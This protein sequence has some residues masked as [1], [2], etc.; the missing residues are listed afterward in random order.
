MET[1]CPVSWEKFHWEV[2]GI[3]CSAKIVRS[4]LQRALDILHMDIEVLAVRYINTS[5]YLLLKSLWFFLLNVEW[6]HQYGDFFFFFFFS[7]FVSGLLHLFNFTIFKFKKLLLLQ[8]MWAENSRNLSK[9]WKREQSTSFF[10]RKL[11]CYSKNYRNSVLSSLMFW[12]CKFGPGFPFGLLNIIFSRM[13]FWASYLTPSM[14]GQALIL[15]CAALEKLANAEGALPSPS[16][17]DTLCQV[18]LLRPVWRGW[19]I[20]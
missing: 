6:Q 18:L 15:G 3:G 4:C 12:P 8:Q 2:L 1:V 10:S 11:K 20:Q 7:K 13:R 19:C 14:E 5:M 9:A 16:W 17:W